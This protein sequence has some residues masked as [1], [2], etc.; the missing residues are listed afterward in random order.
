L[1]TFFNESHRYQRAKLAAGPDFRP[2]LKYE[3][4]IPVL[5]GK[6]PIAL[7][8]ER[9]SV[10]QDA[11]RFAQ[12]QRIKIVILQPRELTPE[13]AEL[14]KSY[15]VPVV[16]GRTLALPQSEDDPY[17]ASFTL[18]AQAYRLGVKFAFGTFDN[19]FV[20]DLPYNAATAVAFGLPYQEALKALTINAA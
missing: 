9:D 14:L 6:M 16:L 5:E 4:M 15:G 19:E 12:T 1:R 13:A 3:A 7:R 11:V 17:D 20:R 2:D 18:P 10:I 8:A